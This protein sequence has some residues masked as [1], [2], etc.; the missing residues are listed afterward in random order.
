MA[1]QPVIVRRKPSAA[2]LTEAEARQLREQISGMAIELVPTEGVKANPRNAK[3]HPQQQV[4][5]IAE[6]IRKFGVNHPIL[7]DEN[8]V[9][10]GG[11]ARMA[12]AHLLKLEHIPAI[13]FPN[14]SPQEKRAVA[15]ADNKLAEL[16]TWNTDIL[17]AELKELITEPELTFDYS[18]TGFDT[19]EIDQ[20]L[21][22]N[23][24]PD[25]PD[26]ADDMPAFP[27]DG[28]PVTNLGDIW[29]CGDHCLHCG[30]A[31]DA[32]SYRAL[33]QGVPA[34]IVFVDPLYG[35]ANTRHL[36]KRGSATNSDDS[37][38]E[39]VD[40][41]Q[42]V[43]VQIAGNVVDGAAIYWSVDWQHLNELSAATRRYFGKP[44]NL[45]VWVKANAGQGSW[46]RSQHELIAVYVAGNPTA[47]T[48]LRL[49][50]RHRY[51][52]NVWTYPDCDMLGRNRDPAPGTGA[53]KPVALLVDALRDCST[54]GQSVLNPFAGFGTAMIA[55]ER[56][57]RRARLIEIEPFNCDVIVRRWQTFSGKNAQLAESNESFAEVETRR[58]R[59]GGGRE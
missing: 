53:V 38:S 56:T 57:G 50:Q 7:I 1:Q 29:I 22:R 27:A 23:A 11:H 31:L 26:P 19:V 15:L 21:G 35:V 42:T 46:Y 48:T 41:L 58:I 16:G 18:I 54:R 44:K 30:N 13:R 6:N 39:L 49:G 9:I 47:T 25:K 43:S 28:A 32:S 37:S 20:L 59:A 34:D 10:I 24:S 2:E 55:A 12:A 3:R 52:T 5:Q 33:L 45:V 51:R 14:L 36:S 17:G 4:L 40:S 8:D